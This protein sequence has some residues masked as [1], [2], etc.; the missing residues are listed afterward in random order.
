MQFMQYSCYPMKCLKIPKSDAVNGK[1]Y[2]TITRTNQTD[3]KTKV[4]KYKYRLS[5]TNPTK[6][7]QKMR[8]V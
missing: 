4:H 7:G 6:D 2:N 5:N 1:T 8:G 3:N